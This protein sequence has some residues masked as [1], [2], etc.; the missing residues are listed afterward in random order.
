[1]WDA[2]NDA[3]DLSPEEAEKQYIEFIEE[4]KNRLGTK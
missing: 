2:W 1:M 4:L 3:K